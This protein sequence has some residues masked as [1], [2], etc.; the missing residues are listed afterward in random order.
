MKKEQLFTSV[1][2]YVTG[3]MDPGLFVMTGQVAPGANIETAEKALLNELEKIKKE[4]VGDYELEKVKNKFEA[5]TI[6]GEIN[7]MNKAMNL[8][9]YDML[10]DIDLVNTE[11]SVYRA[12]TSDDIMQ[13][14]N[15]IFIPENSS[16]LLYVKE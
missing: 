12:I 1:N 2:A 8:C 5:N 16:T 3:D 10:G 4:P 15:R 11:L 6:F 13:T 7:V 9:F 14:A